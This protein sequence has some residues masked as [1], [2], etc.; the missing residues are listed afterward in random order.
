MFLTSKSAISTAHDR[1][2]DDTI[3][4]FRQSAVD[5]RGNNRIL[6]TEASSQ[7]SKGILRNAGIEGPSNCFGAAND[8]LRLGPPA[9]FS[10]GENG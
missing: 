1:G 2:R 5:P 8:S 4:D 9:I 7:P 6:A 3:I 10:T